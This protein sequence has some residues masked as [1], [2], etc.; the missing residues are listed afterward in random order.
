MVVTKTPN[1]KGKGSGKYERM[2]YKLEQVRP[3]EEY[4]QA[5]ENFQ[6][7]DPVSCFLF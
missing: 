1:S 3:V 2:N 5:L 4:K 6:E 7:P